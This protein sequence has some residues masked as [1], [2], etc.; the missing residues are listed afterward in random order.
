MSADASIMILTETCL[1]LGQRV[2]RL[3]AALIRLRDCDWVISLPDR[4]DAVREIARA[5]LNDGHDTD[6][7]TQCQHCGDWF[8]CHSHVF[9]AFE[10]TG[11][12]ICEGC[13][14]N[15]CEENNV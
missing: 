5:A 6:K 12:I 7:E 10:T 14:D 8:E 9:E 1:R 4:M 15:Y 3:E 13:W 11:K 2:A